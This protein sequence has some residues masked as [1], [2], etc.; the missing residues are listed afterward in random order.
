MMV[1]INKLR[2]SMLA[3]PGRVKLLLAIFFSVGLAGFSIPSTREFFMHLTPFA[4]LLSIF[5]LFLYQVPFPDGKTI[6]IFSVIIVSTWLIEAA[7]VATGI[8][9]G[10]Y[11][12]GEGLGIKLLETPL[13]IGINW[14]LMIY[15]SSCIAA[16][17][18]HNPV[19]NVIS[20][21]SLM[22]FYDFIMEN[23]SAELDMW[24]F[25]DGM[26]PLRNYLAWF[27]IAAVIHTVLKIAGI[28][29]NNRIA[30]YI[31]FLQAAFFTLLILIFR[32]SR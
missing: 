32:I 22:V 2:E 23:I 25:D 12:Y 5:V 26:P 20:A 9:F 17:I 21:S 19:L 3:H 28:R 8:I 18:T 24:S 14:L 27:I 15:T 29:F 1:Y 16:S 10:N 13:L 11:S 4:I 31:F 6:I 7:G 30:S